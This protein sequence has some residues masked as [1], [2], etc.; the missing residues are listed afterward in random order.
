MTANDPEDPKALGTEETPEVAPVEAP[1]FE[2]AY[3]EP[4][5][6]T[7]D[8]DTWRSGEDLA[9]LYGRLEREIAEAVRQE[10]G[11]RDRIREEVFPLLRDRPGAPTGVWQA[12]AT[13]I[14][15]VHRGL[16]FAG[17]VEAC[18]ATTATYD[19]LP[20][21]ITQIGVCLVSYRGDSGSWV[22]R[23]YR[24]D[25]RVRGLDPVEEMAQL[26]ERRRQRTG[27]D[28]VSRRDSL[29]DLARRGIM[30]YAERAVLLQK[31]EAPWRMGHG[32]PLAYELLTGSGMS[33]LVDRSLDLLAELV[34]CHQRF[35]FVPSGTADRVLLTIGG[36][37]RPLEYA[38][39]DTMEG[40][41]LTKIIGE[42]HYRGEWAP[43]IPRLRAFA[44]E[45]GS[46]VVVGVFRASPL[47]PAQVF[48]AHKDYAHLAVRIALA[49]SVL[50]VH[51]GFPML[52]DLADALCTATFGTDSLTVSAQNAY[53]ETGA[54][55]QY[56]PERQTRE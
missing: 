19:T 14:E 4:L 51:R 22:Q 31:S 11:V 27:Y 23:M 26:M 15:Q 28:A 7:L 30:T 1:E 16:L 52:I 49:D 45:V 40:W 5:G 20:V 55:F 37:L 42:G 29:S 50:Q 39:V 47:A 10:T 24:R 38:I 46:Q 35:V 8:L 33:V 17:R 54:A 48:Y 3:G 34:L 32:N 53:A 13:E 2:A 9:L 43:L 12:T 41:I 25:L 36:A 44:A 18:D 21:T 6:R 56:F